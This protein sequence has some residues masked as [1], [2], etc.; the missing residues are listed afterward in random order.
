M[1]P[2]NYATIGIGGY[3]ARH[4]AA[5]R[6]LHEEA[7]IRLTAVAEIYQDRHRETL[8]ELSAEGANVYDDY[9]EMLRREPDLDIVSV[10]TPIPLHFP[11][12]LDCFERRMNVFLEKPPAPLI[13]QVDKMCRV[14]EENDCLCQVGFQNISDTA[15]RRLKER[16]SEGA[17]G[18]IKDLTV[19]GTWTRFDGYYERAEWAGRLRLNDTWVLDGPLNNPLC[20]YIHEALFLASSHPHGTEE[21]REVR[22]ELYHAH[23]I[24]GEDLVCARGRLAGGA[25]LHTYL[26]L[27]APESA[28]PRIRIEG[29]RGSA[30]WEPGRY[31]METEEG[32]EEYEGE[33][34][35]CLEL[36]RNF[37][38]GLQGEAPLWSPLSATRNVIL[39]NNGCYRSSGR[40]RALPEEIVKRYVSEKPE[41]NGDT[42]TEIEDVLGLIEEAVDRRCLF[43]EMDL[44]WAGAGETV[45][46]DFDSYD[47]SHLLEDRD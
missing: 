8:E 12:A 41:D 30:L 14:A 3:G 42:V 33:R 27:C 16:L 4:L 6:R 26:T 21:P 11:M 22:A 36:F 24:E 25:T 20:H 34:G 17:L 7:L 37:V 43:S 40:V 29:E 5:A 10:P 15:A 38:R 35:T 19:V 9:R 2:L 28:P 31:E 23:P 13:Q 1:K 46:L 47:P 18:A 32:C 39:H 45:S 44:P